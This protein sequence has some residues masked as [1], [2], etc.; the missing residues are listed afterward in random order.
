MLQEQYILEYREE[1]AVE[2]SVSDEKVL[3]LLSEDQQKELTYI[4]YFYFPILF[5]IPLAW[6][7]MLLYFIGKMYGSIV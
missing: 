1:N 5:L 7:L 6:F 3:S 4:S 2:S